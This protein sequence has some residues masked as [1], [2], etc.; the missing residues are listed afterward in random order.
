MER[1]LIA[2]PLLTHLN[3]PSVTDLCWNGHAELHIDRGSGFERLPDTG[4]RSE[5]EFRQFA[6]D[7]LSRSGRT[8][9]AKLP[10]VDTV[11]FGTHRAHLVFPPVARTGI[12][13]SLRR[14]PRAEDLP[15][16]SLRTSAEIRWKDSGP[17]FGLLKDAVTSQVPLVLCGST[18]SGK[19]T[20]LND[21]LAF[22]QPGERLIALEDTPELS[23]GHPHFTSLVTRPA[24]A[25]GFGAVGLR[26]LVRQTLRMRPDRIL[27][28]E[29]RGDEVLDL[30]QAINT[31][32]RG[33]LTTVHANSAVDALRR[34]ELL[35]LIA[36]QGRIPA[37]LIRALI[38]R[39]IGRIAHL[40][41]STGGR[42]ISE[43]ISVEGCEGEVILSRTLFSMN[44]PLGDLPTHERNSAGKNAVFPRPRW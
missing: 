15:M 43:I 38:G 16:A 28:G 14:L 1:P 19:T 25:D 31:G 10:F 30:L 29:C 9:D 20:L 6:L 3:D 37:A 41:G 21:L 2:L 36:A 44:P 33:S 17:A 11:F 39:G 22:T 24:N 7:A 23:P 8:W 18:G 4:F 13:L 34:L 40:E 42:R 12:H 35:A 32:H 5:T 26:D 27:V